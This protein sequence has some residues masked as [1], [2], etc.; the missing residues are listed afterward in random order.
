MVNI[1]F[2]NTNTFSASS[3]ARIT[4]NVN[5]TGAKNIY[6][7]NGLPTGT[8]TTYFGRANYINT[9][10]YDG[11]C[12]IWVGASADNNSTYANY[13]FGNG[14]GTCAT[15]AATAAKEVTF[16][17]YSLVT[18]GIC[19][20][21]FTYAVPANA[22]LNINTRG[23]KAIRYRGAAIT[24]GVINAGDIGLF[25]YDGTYYE[26]IAVDHNIE[27]A[28]VAETKSYLGIS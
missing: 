15:A 8:N 12:W 24:A 3:S 13:S 28:T 26:L 22:T 11:S 27:I 6:A 14:W 20:I 1:K 7:T 16:A 17:N 4:L 19:A 23:A 9:Y 21:K 2:T 5:N 18:N 10:V 25:V